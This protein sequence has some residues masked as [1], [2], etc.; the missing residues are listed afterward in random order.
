[1]I[2]MEIK[3]CIEQIADLDSRLVVLNLIENQLQEIEFLVE[4][5]NDQQ[6]SLFVRW[7]EERK[8]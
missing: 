1:V 3:K 8:E 4:V 7:L 2:K 5:L 6:L